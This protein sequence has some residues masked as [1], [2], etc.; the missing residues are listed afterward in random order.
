MHWGH[1]KIEERVGFVVFFFFYGK[2]LVI[3]SS[4]PPK[5]LFSSRFSS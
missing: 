5:V 2:T 1:E 3:P 4:F